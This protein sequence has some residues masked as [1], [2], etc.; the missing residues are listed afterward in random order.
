M[1][2]IAQLR[3]RRRQRGA[4]IFIVLLVVTLLTAIGIFTARSATMVDQ[5]AGYDRQLIQTQ[6][7]TEYAGRAVS[8][9]LGDGAGKSYLDKVVQGTDTCQ[10]NENL[11]VITAGAPI[12]CYKLYISEIAARVNTHT[13]NAVIDK[14]TVANAGSL[15]PALGAAGVGTEMDGVFVVEMTDPIESVPKAGS[16]LSGV[17]A[18]AFR[19]VQLTLT[20][21]GQIRPTGGVA[22]AP[23]CANASSSITASVSGLR[24]HVTLKNVPR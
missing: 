18:N 9:E 19:D 13:G 23:W 20:A 24:A 16:Q 6:Y 11:Q 22:V 10:S 8:A 17:G 1:V 14:Q 7:L 4:S 5:A 3:R 2:N 12:P 21:F 15:G